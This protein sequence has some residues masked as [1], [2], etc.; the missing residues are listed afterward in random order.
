LIIR[1]ITIET[2]DTLRFDTAAAIGSILYGEEVTSVGQVVAFRQN[3]SSGCGSLTLFTVVD[4]SS[5]GNLATP[6]Q[7]R[8][9]PNPTQG[10]VDISSIPGQTLLRV[11]D[12]KGALIAE[13]ELN[14]SRA[15]I[16]LT[17]LGASGLTIMQFYSPTGVQTMRVVVE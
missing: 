16:D 6:T 17:R 5:N 14:Q 11:Y 13:R 9:Y 4:A 15:K 8:I 3:P 2:I 12:A 7:I 10:L 1:N